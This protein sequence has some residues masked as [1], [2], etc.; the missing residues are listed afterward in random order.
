MHNLK[1]I[2]PVTQTSESDLRKYLPHE[3]SID[4]NPISG[5]SSSRHSTLDA[6]QIN[7]QSLRADKRVLNDSLFNSTLSAGPAILS[8]RTEL[9]DKV[10]VLQVQHQVSNRFE[11]PLVRSVEDPASL[12][13]ILWENIKQ[14]ARPQVASSLTC[15]QSPL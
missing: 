5:R 2:H 1:F 4:D 9:I 10:P 7:H 14:F 13:E 15:L 3:P 11:I 6:D 8:S 12:W